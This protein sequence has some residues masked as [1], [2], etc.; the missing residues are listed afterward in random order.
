[1]KQEGEGSRETVERM[2]VF[3]TAFERLSDCLLAGT[4]N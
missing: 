2:L 4:A 1:M 3:V